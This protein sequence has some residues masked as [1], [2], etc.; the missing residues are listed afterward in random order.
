MVD[1]V[2]AGPGRYCCAYATPSCQDFL[3]RA[4]EIRSRGSCTNVA[5]IPGQE[6]TNLPSPVVPPKAN[7]SA[8][9]RVLRRARDGVALNIDEAA[10]AMTARGADLVELCASAARVR[11]A[12]LEAA[13]RRGPDGRLAITYSRK[14]FIPVTHLCR[15]SCHY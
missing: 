13:G 5:L 12:G 6:P 14:V 9:R 4:D 7:A 11:D 10:V 3:G 1:R 15:D 8:I 2:A